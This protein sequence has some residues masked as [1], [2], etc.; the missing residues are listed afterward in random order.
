MAQLPIVKGL[1]GKSESE[2][3]SMKMCNT[4]QACETKPH[5]FIQLFTQHT[6]FSLSFTGKPKTFSLGVPKNG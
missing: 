5:F 6:P 4:T 2:Q 1:S 3:L